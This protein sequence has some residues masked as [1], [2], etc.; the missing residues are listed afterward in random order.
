MLT[1]IAR[2]AHR[3]KIANYIP[4][5]QRYRNH[6]IYG[7][8]L[9]QRFVAQVA[10]KAI[11]GSQLIPRIVFVRHFI[12]ASP[13]S[14]CS[15]TDNLWV[16]LGIVSMPS[17]SYF[18]VS[19][20]VLTDSSSCTVGVISTVLLLVLALILALSFRLAT[21]SLISFLPCITVLVIVSWPANTRTQRITFDQV[22]ASFLIHA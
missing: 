16:G 13:A 2:P 3:P 10:S 18:F 9:R 22:S 1:A 20:I 4:A 12:Q 6:V 17:R 15:V 7:P 11:Q 14:P 8:V 19:E 5:S 21:S